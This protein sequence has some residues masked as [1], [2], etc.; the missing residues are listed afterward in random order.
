M[1]LINGQ[2]NP[3]ALVIL[4]TH[5]DAF[6]CDQYG[7]LAEVDVRN[8]GAM[9]LVF[10]RKPDDNTGGDKKM[11]EKKMVIG[12]LGGIASGKT[13][14]ARCFEPLGC[15]VIEADKLAHEILQEPDTKEQII[16]LFG[17]GVID[18]DGRVNRKSL[19]K[20]AFSDYHALKR[21]DEL[22]QP[23]VMVQVGALIDHY[24][25]DG[26]VKAIVLDAP[27][28]AEVDRLDC[29]DVLVFVEASEQIRLERLKKSGKFDENELK[30][31]ENF[32]IS[33]DKKRKIAHYVV[34]NNSDLSDVAEQ[35]AQLFSTLTSNK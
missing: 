26:A 11:T 22:V 29:C 21:L 4:R 15:A 12:I 7:Q 1:E 31:R 18:A 16:S 33:L 6:T 8:W 13:T 3:G 20:V 28:L 30:K 10:Y 32:Q 2:V 9:K 27:L 17:D 5:E 35:V 14:V 24:Q 34:R 25:Q 23:K 19:A